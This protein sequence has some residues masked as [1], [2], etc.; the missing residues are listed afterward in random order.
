MS[1]V[2]C[3]NA[4]IGQSVTATNN[5]TWYQPSSPDGTVRLGNGN[6]GSVTDLITVGS[7]GNLTF[8]GTTETYSN[9]VT[10]SAASTKTLTLNG[11][12]LT[13]GLVID[14]SNNVGIGTASSG[15]KLYVAGS[16][17][18]PFGANG[19]FSD[20]TS[21]KPILFTNYDGTSN[22]DY[23]QIGSPA[24]SAGVGTDI[25]FNTGTFA[26][27]GEK[28]RLDSSGNL[29]VGTTN[30]NGSSANSTVTTLGVVRT[31]GTSG[32]LGNASA[33]TLFTIPANSAWI[34][35]IQTQNAAGLSTTAIVSYVSGGSSVKVTQI[36]V[37]NVNFYITFSGTTIQAYNNLGGVINYGATA[38]RLY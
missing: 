33:G 38:L 31:V 32:S 28:M 16:I 21:R 30:L 7:T 5:F 13:N 6:S 25:R 2:K 20:S 14:A 29:L 8:T 24:V 35:N 34:V 4:Q 19:V 10:I 9:S 11:G 17:L 1:T 22:T 15:A 18:F 36:A 27:W 26:G 37:D 3:N 12:G 23:L